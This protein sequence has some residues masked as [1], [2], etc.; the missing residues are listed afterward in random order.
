M[1]RLRL[2]RVTPWATSVALGGY[3]F[4]GQGLLAQTRGDT[5]AGG[6]E[7]NGFNVPQTVTNSGRPAEKAPAE[8]P[9]DKTLKLTISAMARID[10]DAV[11]DAAV[12]EEGALGRSAAIHLKGTGFPWQETANVYLAGHRSGYPRTDGLLA[13]WDLNK[14]EEGDE[15]FV[16][17]AE[18]TGRTYGVL[19]EFVAE[20]TD[21]SVTEPAPGENVLTLQTCT[22]P[23]YRD[24]LIV[25]AELVDEVPGDRERGERRI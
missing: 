14:L 4:L 12:G 8:G 5:A 24:R 2:R 7:P 25:R 16:T 13:F 10:D 15:V 6:G 19:R 3:F 21:L 17:G 22:L 20:P 11:P 23:D 1:V 9:E 18:D